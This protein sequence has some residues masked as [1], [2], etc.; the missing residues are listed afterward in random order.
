MEDMA[1]DMAVGAMALVTASAADMAL[2]AAITS[3]TMADT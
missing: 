1:V 3:D 2:A